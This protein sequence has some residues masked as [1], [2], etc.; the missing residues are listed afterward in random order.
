[1]ISF[2]SIRFR[3]YENPLILILLHHQT[4]MHPNSNCSSN[5]T[6]TATTKTLQGHSRER[7]RPAADTISAVRARIVTCRG[8]ACSFSFWPCA[9]PFRWSMWFTLPNISRSMWMCCIIIT[10]RWMFDGTRQVVPGG[11]E[12]MAFGGNGERG[13][14]WVIVF[15]DG[16][17]QC[18]GQG[19]M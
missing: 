7:F 10:I 16:I 19:S 8:C 14:G 15:V 18:R 9:L 2:Q 6:T 12:L 4:K 1:M 11:L 13:I 17:R 3:W 5:R